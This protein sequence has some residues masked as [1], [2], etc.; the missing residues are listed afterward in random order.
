MK[1]ARTGGGRPNGTRAKSQNETRPA[2]GAEQDRDSRAGRADPDAG[3]RVNSEWHAM[4]DALQTALAAQAM[5]RAAL[6]IAEQ[7][8]MFSRQ[9]GAGVLQDRGAEDALKLFAALLRETSTA[10]LTPAGHA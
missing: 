9:F 7:A 8:E 6:V 2:T 10:S 3:R 1:Q 5:H 4:S